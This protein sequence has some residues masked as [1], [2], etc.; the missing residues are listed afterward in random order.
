MELNQILRL[1]EY[2]GLVDKGEINPSELE[3]ALKLLKSKEDAQRLASRLKK[4]ALRKEV[5]RARELAQSFTKNIYVSFFL[6][7]LE[8]KPVAQVS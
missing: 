4:V 8:E 7:A 1:D 2:V 3:L 5:K 6:D